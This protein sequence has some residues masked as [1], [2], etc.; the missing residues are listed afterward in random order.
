[1]LL[2]TADCFLIAFF[3]YD[4]TQVLKISTTYSGQQAAP[5]R[6]LVELPSITK[7]TFSAPPNTSKLQAEL[8]MLH[9]KIDLKSKESAENQASL[10]K[11]MTD[12]GQ[13]QIQQ[14]ME[15]K[16]LTERVGE[17]A[18]DITLVKGTFTFSF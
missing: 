1:M 16:T 7:Q 3:S 4:E 10:M 13:M 12:S 9:N 15:T 8:Q 18:N 2:I 5:N 6:N 17:M 14:R 11:I